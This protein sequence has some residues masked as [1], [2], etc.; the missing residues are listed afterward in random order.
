VSSWTKRL[1]NSS[2]S[3]D[4]CGVIACLLACARAGHVGGGLW[5]WEGRARG[6]LAHSSSCGRRLVCC[7]ARGRATRLAHPSGRAFRCPILVK[8]GHHRSADQCL[9]YPRKRTLKLS[10]AMS[11]GIRKIPLGTVVADDAHACL[12]TA[13]EQ[14]SIRITEESLYDQLLSLFEDD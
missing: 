4:S 14:F 11:V 7:S 12:A 1:N 5:R 8:N 6:H 9:L 2:T 3:S 10:R 13:T